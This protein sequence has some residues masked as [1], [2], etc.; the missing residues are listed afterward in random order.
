MNKSRHIQHTNF[1]NKFISRR[2]FLYF[3]GAAGISLAAGCAANPVTGR[4][5][6]MLMSESQEIS[7]DKQNS[8]HQISADY[9][10]V[11]DKALNNYVSH[12]GQTV[13][14]TSHRPDM[15]FSF[16]TLNAPYVNAYAFPGGTIGITRGILLDL[17]NEAE[18]AS[19][20]GHEAGHVAARHTSQRMSRGL[21]ASVVLAG[22]SASVGS[23]LGDLVSGLGGI[24]AGALLAGYSR[25]Q[26]R[27]ADSLGLEYMVKADYNPEGFVGLMDMLNEMSGKNENSMAVL[28]ST[29]P[30]G[31]ERYQTA[32]REV[33]T[34][35]QARKKTRPIFRERFMD[36]T[37][38]LRKIAPTIKSLQDGDEAMAQKDPQKAREQYQRALKTTPNDY[39][40]N[41]KMAKCNMALENHHEANSFARKAKEVYPQE[42]QA[43]H[44]TGMTNLKLKRFNQALEEFNTYER[45]LPGNPNTVF[46][47]GFSLEGLR[48]REPAARKY[49][50]YLQMVSQGEYAQHAHARLQEWGYI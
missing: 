29:H 39:A 46:F 40:A 12:V 9:G 49:Y 10:V 41:L 2:N 32:L 1:T 19:L 6:L 44:V 37:A 11:R 36:N 33:E 16:H 3:T 38:N 26:E 8:P 13:V 50:D 4:Q 48:Q 15:P 25:N 42:P 35:Y 34:R 20:I 7:I 14:R 30:M 24:G 27:E 23:N 43:I 31:S 21:L 18:L 5:E 28:F 22:V 45:I 17:D 47:Q